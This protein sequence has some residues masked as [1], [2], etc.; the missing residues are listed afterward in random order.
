MDK[1]KIFHNENLERLTKDN[2]VLK[3][4]L[5]ILSIEHQTLKD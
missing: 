3:D 4:I 1:M 2:I 5:D